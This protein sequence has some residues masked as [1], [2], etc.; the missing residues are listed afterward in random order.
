MYI[1]STSTVWKIEKI[2][3]TGKGDRDVRWEKAG[4]GGGGTTALCPCTI[5]N[6]WWSQ[7]YK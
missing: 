5:E 4:E 7:Y 3:D 6:C 2:K 1:L